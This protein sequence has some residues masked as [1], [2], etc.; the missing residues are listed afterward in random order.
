MMKNDL[1]LNYTQSHL[2]EIISWIAGLVKIES[3]TDNKIAVNRAVEYVADF[4]AP[5][6]KVKLR[7]QQHYGNHLRIEFNLPGYRKTSQILGLGHLDT[8]WPIGTIKRMPCKKTSGRL[9]GP[10]V[11]DMKSGVGFLIFA[12]QAIREVDIPVHHR[13]VLQLNSDEEIGSPSSRPFT[14]AEAKKSK[15]V[16]VAEPSAGLDGRAKT[17]RKGG[18]MYTLTVKGRAAHSGLDFSTGVSAVL[19][20][21]RQLLKI[22]EWSDVDR[23]VTVNPG[24]ICGGTR[25]NVVPEIAWAE[26]DVRTPLPVDARKIERRF[27]KIEPINSCTSVIVEGGIRRPPLIRSRDVLKL[28][29]KA[30]KFSTEMGFEL[31]EACVGG[32]SDGNFTAALGTPTLD[33]LGG[34]GEGAHATNESILVD[35][36]ADRTALLAKLIAEMY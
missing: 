22:S 26:I 13:F 16:F 9:W 15:A 12:A 18:G 35:R 33:G 1:I 2:S 36:I 5:F 3:P 14:E 17:A 7:R 34:V 8:V 29:R 32:G 10:G 25:S 23:G 6:A 30:R 19:E 27:S 24:V 4:V 11:F 28:H 21:S 31:G 20:L